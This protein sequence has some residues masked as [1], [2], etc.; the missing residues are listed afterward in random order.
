MLA[1]EAWG[2]SPAQGWTGVIKRLLLLCVLALSAC[3]STGVGNPPTAWLP[4]EATRSSGSAGQSPGETSAGPSPS[5]VTLLTLTSDESA[6]EDGLFLPPG[7]VKTAVLTIGAI[8]VLPCDLADGIQHLTGPFDVDLEDEEGF[9]LPGL[10]N[11]ESGVCSLL[12]A[13][14]PAGSDGRYPGECVHLE[15]SFDTYQVT[16][17]TSDLLVLHLRTKD[18]AEWG[19][20]SVDVAQSVIIAL[21]PERWLLRS[22]VSLLADEAGELVVDDHMPALMSEVRQRMQATSTLHDDLDR[23]RLLDGAETLL[24]AILGTGD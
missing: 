14:V 12:L 1:V 20:A 16:L 2:P 8:L 5:Q 13:V 4:P 10:V 6:D 11:P 21:R 23:D 18:D 3:D 7:A 9:E 24:E 15:A 19:M 17:T 22:E